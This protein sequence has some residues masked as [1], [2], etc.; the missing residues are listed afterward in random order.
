M[1]LCS[2]GQ[3]DPDSR[4]TEDV[5]GVS[6]GNE[7]E[8]SNPCEESRYSCVD[9]PSVFLKKCAVKTKKM[10]AG[11]AGPLRISRD[12]LRSYRELIG[13]KG[14]MAFKQRVLPMA[15]TILGDRP[16][17]RDAVLMKLIDAASYLRPAE[18]DKFWKTT[19]TFD[20]FDFQRR[21]LDLHRPNGHKIDGKVFHVTERRILQI[22]KQLIPRYMRD[23]RPYKPEPPDDSVESAYYPHDYYRVCFA[24]GTIEMLSAY[25]LGHATL[26]QIFGRGGTE[27][28]F[29]ENG[30]FVSAQFA[31]AVVDRERTAYAGGHEIETIYDVNGRWIDEATMGDRD[32]GVYE[33]HKYVPI[34]AVIEIPFTVITDDQISELRRQGREFYAT[35]IATGLASPFFEIRDAEQAGDLFAAVRHQELAVKY[36]L[37][38]YAER[39]SKPAGQL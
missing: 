15:A 31:I 36:A 3:S 8:D 34:D 30:F 39:L 9:S 27:W 18:I 20:T 19:V 35:K 1:P 22:V 28:L 5:P 32:V 12:V 14:L 6:E 4:C 7:P 16:E 37:M 33:S 2:S 23:G 21:Y 25:L 11:D 13:G 24:D 38:R 10:S 26:A 17:L 29:E